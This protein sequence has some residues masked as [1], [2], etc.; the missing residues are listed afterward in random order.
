MR[1]VL[2]NPVGRKLQ[3]CVRRGKKEIHEPHGKGTV[4]GS[5]GWVSE[6]RGLARRSEQLQ[7]CSADANLVR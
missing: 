1:C 7:P 3:P 4:T 6:K 5:G 2:K